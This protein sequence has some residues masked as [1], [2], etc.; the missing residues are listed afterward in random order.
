MGSVFD[1]YFFIMIVVASL[2]VFFV[3]RKYFIKKGDINL[4]RKSRII[5]IIMVILS[6]ILFITFKVM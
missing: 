5:P 4:Y 3:D 1:I 2:Y 6:T